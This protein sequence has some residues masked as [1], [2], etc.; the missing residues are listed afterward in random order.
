M[1]WDCLSQN[2]QCHSLP[3][4]QWK[5]CDGLSFTKC[6]MSLTNYW[7]WEKMWWDCHSQNGQYHSQ[8]VD[9]RKSCDETAFHRMCNVTHRLLVRGKHVMRLPFTKYAMSLTRCWSWKDV[10]DCLSQNVQCHSLAVGH[11]KRCYETGFHK[12]CTVLTFCFIGK[13]VMS[14]FSEIFAML[15][16]YC[17]PYPKWWQSHLLNH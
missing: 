3:V 10:M 7:S 17:W 16:T 1:W 12:M 2:V 5:G 6:V 13:D 9:H 14:S 4:D 11:R 8:T 15:L